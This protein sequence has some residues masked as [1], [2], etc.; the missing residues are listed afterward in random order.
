M[1][2]KASREAVAPSVAP[3]AVFSRRTIV[4]LVLG[5]GVAFCIMLTLMI[6]GDPAG[7]NVTTSS[8]FSR[9]AVGHKAL[10]EWLRAQG[11]EV[12]VN[13]SREAADVAVG[14]LLLILAPNTADH[15]IDHLRALA[16]A[17]SANGAAVLVALP[18]WRTSP[19]GT[20]RGWISQANMIK[21]ER[22]A[23]PLGA[24]PALADGT[25]VR[26]ND[27][28]GW[29]NAI[30]DAAPNIALPQF[31]DH[32]G[33]DP[34]VSS[35]DNVLV[36]EVPNTRLAVLADVDL[37]ANHG[38]RQGDNAEL[39]LTLVNRLAPAHGAVVFDETLHGFA[40]VPSLWRLLFQPP[41][42]GATLLALAAMALTVWRATARFGAPLDARTGAAFRS[43]H[44]QL[45]ENAGRLLAAGGHGT[46]LAQRYAQMTVAEARR[47]LHLRQE[48][49]ATDTAFAA[50]N[51]VGERRGVRARLP[52]NVTW[53]RPLALARDC[54]RWTREMFGDA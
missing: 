31:I 27:V 29:R 39:A 5:G 41:H 37:L 6:V 34:L 24:I 11:R 21:L 14:D 12:K 46:L 45:I 42:L 17:A 10:A 4:W 26:A 2:A 35:A 54:Q 28:P 53:Q 19:S 7:G 8:V 25:V 13:R 1:S 43:G 50:L 30:G 9:S 49:V 33:L 3:K 23:K 16:A 51:A 48:S 15:D 52:A 47:R 20:T 38:L 44:G 36:G 22:A 18:K 40:I 32:G